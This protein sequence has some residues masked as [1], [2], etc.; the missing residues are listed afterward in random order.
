MMRIPSPDGLSRQMMKGRIVMSDG[1]VLKK[2]SPE[3]DGFECFEDGV[4]GAD[5]PEGGGVIRGSLVKFTNEAAWLLR[6]DE[7]MPAGRNW[8]PSTLFAS[9]SG[10]R[11]NCRRRPHP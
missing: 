8:L 5:R 2:V 10:G 11:T 6:D 3:I 1:R 7:E 9:C 4:E